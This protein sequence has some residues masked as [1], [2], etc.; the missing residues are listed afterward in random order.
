MKVIDTRSGKPITVGQTIEHGDGESVT[1]LEVEPGLLK[2]RAR[3]STT[4]RDLARAVDN[5]PLRVI[6]SAWVPLTVRWTHPTFFLEHVGF[7]PS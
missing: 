1:L 7:L 5:P 6:A 3:V 2:A 4:F